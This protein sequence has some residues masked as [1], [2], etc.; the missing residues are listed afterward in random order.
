M[1]APASV[2][3]IRWLIWDTFRQSLASS[4]F[5]VML[6]VSVVSIAFCLG[7]SMRDVPFQPADETPERIPV[8]EARKKDP[9]ELSKSGVDVIQG[10]LNFLFGAVHV[11][12]LK[13]R[14]DAVRWIQLLLASYIADTLG[15]LLALIWTAGFLPTFLESSSVTVLLAKPVPRWSLLVGKVI[16]VLV[17]VTFQAT[18]FVGG[19]WLALAIRTGVWN[20]TYLWCVPMLV[21]HFAIFFSFSCMLAVWT[22]SAIVA[23]F[24][25]LL[26]W[27]ICWGMNYGRHA[28]LATP[29]AQAESRIAARA[30][31]LVGLGAAIDLPAAVTATPLALADDVPGGRVARTA[32]NALEVGYWVLPKPADVGIV[33][34]KL[35]GAD[36]HV[37]QL[38]EFVAVEKAGQLHL[39]WS[40]LA[41]CLFALVML[42]IAGHEFV[43]ADY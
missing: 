42:A 33:L 8:G 22:R 6:G 12:Y 9:F 7:T 28:S 23:V 18:V 38:P 11:P 25:S 3:V 39:E 29:L 10:E 20:P 17:F 21:L 41:S 37:A 34:G 16:G 15:L 19:T 5:W 26:F 40:V 4:I 27:A 2:L 30:T 13:Y 1:N 36:S 24:G 35:L 31:T 32:S 14:E 43:Q